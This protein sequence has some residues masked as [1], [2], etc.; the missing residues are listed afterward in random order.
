[1]FVNNR[2]LLTAALTDMALPWK[3]VS[4]EGG[5][6]LMA[7]ITPCVD[8]IPDKYLNT[9]DYEPE[10]GRAPIAKNRIMMPNG[11]I[12][13]DLAFCR[14]MA[15]EK[16]VTMMP[17]SFFYGKDSPTMT[18]QYVRLAICKDTQS[19]QG[20]IDRLRTALD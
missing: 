16:G 8:L 18:D 4:C 5:Y 9:H 11:A 12:P 13:R 19:T 7:D 6:F 17:N 10:D 2:D 20:A 14:W 15:I 3:P 1:M